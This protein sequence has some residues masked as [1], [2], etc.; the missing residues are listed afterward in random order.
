MAD[1]SDQSIGRRRLVC[2]P[3][4]PWRGGL[5]D[6]YN[7]NYRFNT[8][9][10]SQAGWI[11]DFTRN[12]IVFPIIGL[13]DYSLEVWFRHFPWPTYYRNNATPVGFNS[14]MCGYWVAGN[15]HG[16]GF[17][18]NNCVMSF[19][20]GTVPPGWIFD[21]AVVPPQDGEWH[22]WCATYA[23]AGNATFYIDG[24]VQGAVDISAQVA[25]N[26]DDTGR[27]YIGMNRALDAFLGTAHHMGLTGAFAF[28]RAVLTTAEI[29]DSVM[30]R[31]VQTLVTTEGAWDFRANYYIPPEN[32]RFYDAETD[33]IYIPQ[34]WTRDVRRASL[35]AL[36]FYLIIPDLSGNSRDMNLRSS[37]S[38]YWV[39]FDPSWK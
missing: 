38:S 2:A 31:R 24:V 30:G 36:P 32:V 20:R 25:T 3:R 18:G 8:L 27:R 1:S 26:I 33:P 13:D 35:S 17:D 6:G 15:Y 19:G 7:K 9:A 22:H 12:A 10:D 23:R 29:K 5:D 4:A 28:H 11:V 14:V 21:V 16:L 37:P 39:S 34:G